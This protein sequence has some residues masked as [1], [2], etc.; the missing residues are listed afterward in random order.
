MK[1][2]NPVNIDLF[3]HY[4]ETGSYVQTSDIQLK[5]KLKNIII[6]LFQGSAAVWRA[7]AS[8]RKMFLCRLSWGRK[9][10]ECLSKVGLV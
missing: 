4:D 7:T 10:S 9:F 8:R 1:R 6:S 3:V 2:L 5:I